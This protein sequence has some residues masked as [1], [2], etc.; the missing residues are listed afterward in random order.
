MPTTIGPARPPRPASSAGRDVPA[1]ETR[2][3]LIAG[4]NGCSVVV[5]IAV[6]QP[7][8]VNRLVL[9]R[10][11]TALDADAR[12][13]GQG[14]P[15]AMLAG[16]TLPGL[17]DAELGLTA[18][19]ALL[20]VLF[21]QNRRSWSVC[22]RIVDGVTDLGWPELLIVAVIAMMLFGSKK[23]PDIARS[24]G[25]SMRILKAEV[26]GLRDDDTAVRSEPVAG[27]PAAQPA[28]AVQPIAVEPV[29]VQPVVV[30]PIAPVAPVRTDAPI[31]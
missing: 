31:R 28:A 11:A 15:A 19:F 8:R 2:T 3:H 24:L 9:G 13:L 23:M 10:P 22:G 6:E 21:W 26:G 7:A 14:V 17:A 5:R 16:D 4:S 29:T 20:R 18:G 25:R 30:E 12:T 1:E 27:R